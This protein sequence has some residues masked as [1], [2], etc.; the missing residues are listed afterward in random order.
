MGAKQRVN[1]V[2][3]TPIHS[4]LTGQCPPDQY[5]L[6]TFRFANIPYAPLE[7]TTYLIKTV[8]WSIGAAVTTFLPSHVFGKELQS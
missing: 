7:F 2:A 4:I 1:H 5:L 6:Y 3:I 8:Q